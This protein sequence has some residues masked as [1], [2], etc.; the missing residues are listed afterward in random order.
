MVTKRPLVA[1]LTQRLLAIWSRFARRVRLEAENLI[2]R[3]QLIV[4]RR[5]SP[6]RLIGSVRR[7]SLYHLIVFDEAQLR[8]VLKNYASYTTRS[9][10]G[11][12]ELLLWQN[13]QFATPAWPI[14]ARGKP[15]GLTTRLGP[16]VCT[17]LGVGATVNQ[18]PRWKS[19]LKP[20]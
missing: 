9:G 16:R 4:L 12:G 13:Q 5:K 15:F 1:F 20:Q 19:Q 8:R 10:R 7:E 17:P 11:C 2:L 18:N 14:A 6:A 3:Q